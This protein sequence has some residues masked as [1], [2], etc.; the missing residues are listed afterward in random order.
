M[1]IRLM[2]ALITLLAFN[3]AQANGN[4]FGNGGDALRVLF[5]KAR[6]AAA[7]K[8]DELKWCS[9]AE[10]TP[11]ETA[12]WILKNQAD[13]II[14][15]QRSEH[16][17]VVDSQATCGFT[18]TEK[19]SGIYLSYPTCAS[20]VGTNLKDAMFVILHETAHHFGVTNEK[21]ADRFAQIVMATK[22]GV[23]CPDTPDI[24]DPKSCS[25]AP[26]TTKDARRYFKTGDTK[27]KGEGRFQTWGRISRCVTLTGCQPWK[28]WNANFGYTK[29]KFTRNY[30]SGDYVFDSKFPSFDEILRKSKV[31]D[32]S[33]RLTSLS[34]D[35]NATAG[36]PYFD[37][38]LNFGDED[39]KILKR[40]GTSS[41][42]DP[43]F[44]GISDSAFA[45]Q[46]SEELEYI[47]R[48]PIPYPVRY[49]LPESG[50][51]RGDIYIAGRGYRGDMTLTMS[52]ESDT[53][54]L[55]IGKDCVWNK[56][57]QEFDA[58]SGI[59]EK[60]EFYLLG[61]FGPK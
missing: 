30:Q 48:N 24:T 14:D 34:I 5:E 40:I 42:A 13:L 8:I 52:S 36:S 32:S 21:E 10:N 41:Q 55:K 3:G 18:K 1:K 59:T 46:V 43:D 16:L 57:T 12:E 53:K 7:A 49:I 4:G 15:I 58:G 61:V 2:A 22:K 27:A 50:V 37:F 31:E 38:S 26:M 28:E 9:F 56:W 20:T 23:K 6:T 44:I 33:S 11:S 19:Q 51:E 25:S 39:G 54:N 29:Q 60:V 47:G 17:W 35:L 45:E